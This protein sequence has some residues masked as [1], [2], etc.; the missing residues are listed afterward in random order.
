ML[1]NQTKPKGGM[2]N[3]V[4]SGSVFIKVYSKRDLQNI[5]IENMDP[6]T[7]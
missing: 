1:L 5:K 7:K 4:T 3:V 6:N 2:K